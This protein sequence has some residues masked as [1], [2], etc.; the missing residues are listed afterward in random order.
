MDVTGRVVQEHN[1]DFVQ[2][3]NLNQLSEGMY[4]LRSNGMVKSFEVRH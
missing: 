4:W 3:I 1:G 2:E